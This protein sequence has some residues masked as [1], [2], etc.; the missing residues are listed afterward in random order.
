LE[1]VS[2]HERLLFR[3]GRILD[4]VARPHGCN[5]AVPIDVH[6]GL[7]QLGVPCD[8]LTTREELVARLWARKRSL[9]ASLQRGWGGDPG[10]TPPTAA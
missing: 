1:Y 5:E 3:L 6:A 2:E 9:L 7:W 4:Q 8:E 10:V